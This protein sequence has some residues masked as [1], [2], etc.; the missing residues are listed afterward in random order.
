MCIVNS[1]M[2]KAETVAGKSNST[3]AVTEAKFF[4][5]AQYVV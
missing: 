2:L 5:M 4:S 3:S 1:S